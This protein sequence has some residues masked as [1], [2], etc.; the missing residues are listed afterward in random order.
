MDG[1]AFLQ[2]ENI[3]QEFSFLSTY[4]VKE[5]PLF[6]GLREGVPQ[7]LFL[8]QDYS[9]GFGLPKA[10]MPSPFLMTKS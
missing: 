2:V 10:M 5:P 9:P 4:I 3:F 1:S 6:K 8:I 7:F